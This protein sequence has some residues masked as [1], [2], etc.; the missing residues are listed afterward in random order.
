MY[1]PID[2]CLLI[3]YNIRMKK[4]ILALILT[5][6]TAAA[7]QANIIPTH[8]TSIK[9]TGIGVFILPPTFTLYVE[10]CENSP[11]YDTIVWNEK[12]IVQSEK[13]IKTEDLFI[14]FIPERQLGLAAVEDERDEWV[15]IYLNQ[16]TEADVPSAWV[17][18]GD[19]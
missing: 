9:S 5:V 15:Q 11:V 12:G 19:V 17:K 7:V 13:K 4:F 8:T 3:V 18:K 14:A 6:F 1:T 10:D 2:F 16:R